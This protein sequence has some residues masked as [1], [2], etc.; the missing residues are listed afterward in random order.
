[1]LIIKLLSS[2]ILCAL[3]LTSSVTTLDLDAHKRHKK[4]KHPPR[5]E[6]I[7]II[8]RTTHWG[9]VNR[10]TVEDFTALGLRLRYSLGHPGDGCTP[11]PRAVVLC[12]M[13]IF[14]GHLANA[15]VG[16][17]RSGARIAYNTLH[18]NPSQNVACHEFMHVLAAVGDNYGADDES[19]V[20]GFRLDDPGAT[21]LELLRKA[22][23]IS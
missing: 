7:Q 2:L 8:D 18:P 1:V 3:L 10:E 13:E 19:C 5:P 21:D 20:W 4:H 11:Q 22:G 16:L 12:E 14:S 9:A 17:P 23:R 6:T 15:N